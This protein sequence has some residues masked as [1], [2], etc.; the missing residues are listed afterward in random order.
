[1]PMNIL[2]ADSDARTITGRIVTW[3]EA[4]YTN[5]G[6]TIFAQDSIA[7][8]PIKLLLEHQNTQPIGR[9]LEFNHVND[10]NGT[11]IGID[12]SFKIAK[13]YLGDAA[14]EE[15]AMGLRD[16]FSVGIKLNEWKE[17]DGAFRVLS[18]NLV[19][20]SLVESPAIDSARVSEVAASEEPQKEEEEMTDTPKTTEPEV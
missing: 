5:A 9:V 3:N 6:K 16:G 4:G 18:S 17:E 2:A 14:L 12:A 10:E 15:A 11:P 20:V 1:M 19:E 7:L 13:T 8:K